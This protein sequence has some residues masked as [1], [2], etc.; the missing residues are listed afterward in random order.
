ML[1]ALDDERPDA[2]WSLG[3]VVGYGPRPNPCCEH[4]AARA[5]VSLAGNHDL[6]VLGTIDLVDFSPDAAAVALW[7]REVLSEEARS[8]LMELRPEGRAEG[9]DLFH[10]SASDPVWD[11]VVSGE[12]ALETLEL[13]EGPLVLVGHSH[14]ALSVLLADEVLTGGL[15]PDGTQLDLAAGRWLLNP[16]SVGQPRD[17]DP[18]A[19]Y[20][21]LDLAAGRA[22]FRRAEYDVE[23]TQAEL[24]DRGLPD[25][26]VER[27]ARGV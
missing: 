12:A 16:G 9:A 27:L 21:L 3:D 15:A 1:R 24:R 8:Y 23:R 7:T 13:T 25:F 10:A 2:V 11:Y 26:L 18:R 14:L 5:D 6:G 19:A 20:L 22:T 17:G 4:V